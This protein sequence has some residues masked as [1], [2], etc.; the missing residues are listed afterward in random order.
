[1][2]GDSTPPASRLDR[3]LAWYE[4]QGWLRAM[5]QMVPIG[6]GSIDSLLAWRG[7]HLNQVRVEE[8]IKNLSDKLKD[9]GDKLNEKTL[10]S[11]EF[12]EVFRTCAET[13]AH[14][15][16]ESKRERVASFLAGTVVHG[17]KDLTLHIADDLESLQD[18]HFQLIALLPHAKQQL[19]HRFKPKWDETFNNV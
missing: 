2:N 18:Y 1:M 14:S 11:E 17:C 12:F 8:L 13:A 3:Q 4:N 15:C 16:S 9:V 7:T 10:Q 5:V 19:V 6:G